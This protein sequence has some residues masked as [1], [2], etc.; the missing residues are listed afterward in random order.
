VAYAQVLRERLTATGLFE[1]THR[2]SARREPGS[3]E[4][5]TRKECERLMSDI[6]RARVRLEERGDVLTE[7]RTRADALRRLARYRVESDSV[8]EPASLAEDDSVAASEVLVED[9]WEIYRV[10]LR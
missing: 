9:C 7:I 8:P 6:Q 2:A 10:L 4:Y 3:D 5:G 1:V